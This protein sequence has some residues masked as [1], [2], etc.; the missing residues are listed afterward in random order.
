MAH[1]YNG[2]AANFPTSLTLPDDLD[3]FVAAAFNTPYEGLADRTANLQPRVTVITA[4]ASPYTITAAV[5][6]IA[7]NHAA[8]V[9]ILLPTAPAAGDEYEVLDVA[10]VANAQNI[11]VDSGAGNII[12]NAAAAGAQTFVMTVNGSGYRFKCWDAGATKKWKLC[13]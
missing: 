12:Q 5:K 7:V 1:T 8:P 3:P 4:A 11:T 9:S 10:C 2:N 13:T 6:T